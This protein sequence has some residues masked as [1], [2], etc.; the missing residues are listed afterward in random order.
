M[1]SGSSKVEPVPTQMRRVVL[2]RPAEEI[3]DAQLE[4]ETVPVPVPSSGE[5]LIRVVAAPVNPSDYGKF[6]SSGHGATDATFA[7]VPMGNEGSGVVIASGG[8]IMA[9][10]L[11]GKSVGFVNLKKQGS[12]SEYVTASALTAV[13]PL[14]AELP[15]EDAASF[16]VNPFTAVAII[17]TVRSRGANAFVHTGAASQ[18]GQ[19]IAKYTTTS[20]KDMTVLH[21]VRREEQAATLRAL[22]A[23]HILVTAGDPSSWKGELKKQIAA[24]KITTAFDCIAGEMTQ[25]LVDALPKGSTTFVYGRLSGEAARVAPL[26]L[27][28]FNKKLQG[29]C[30]HVPR[31]ACAACCMR[32]VLQRSSCGAPQRSSCRALGAPCRAAV[33]FSFLAQRRPPVVPLPT[34]PIMPASWCSLLASRSCLFPRSVA[35]FGRR[36]RQPGMDQHGQACADAGKA[37]LGGQGHHALTGRGRMGRQQVFGLHVGEVARRF[38]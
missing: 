32:R 13:F 20:A 35:Q 5:V 14:P 8:G 9:N 11:V 24:L 10:G 17:D 3:A 18:L 27:I 16:Y 21:V 1:G 26:D 22:G 28:Y 15:V 7:K 31:A 23:Q 37:S 36:P 30:V 29:L 25:T 4:V 12:W 33:S 38:S 19:M 6:K 34:R 2:V